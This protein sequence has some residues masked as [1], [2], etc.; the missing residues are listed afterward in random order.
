MLC[1]GAE[2]N[3]CCQNE[4]Q[5]SCTNN[6]KIT[7]LGGDKCVCVGGGVCYLRKI[8][9]SIRI[10]GDNLI[11]FFFYKMSYICACKHIGEFE[12]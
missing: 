8:T 12:R 5:M 2:P 1:H 6:T 4:R 9:S 11:F 3:A 7:V 10:C